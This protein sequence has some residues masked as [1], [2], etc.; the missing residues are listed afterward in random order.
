MSLR[1]VVYLAEFSLLFL[2]WMTF[3]VSYHFVS[4]G[5]WRKTPEGR[6]MMTMS[7]S[8]TLIGAVILCNLFLGEYPGRFLVGVTVYGLI[9]LMGLRQLALL[10]TARRAHRRDAAR[11]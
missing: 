9:P 2:V 1:N 4:D 7:A 5:R 6:H 10:L 3:T 11:K 8:L